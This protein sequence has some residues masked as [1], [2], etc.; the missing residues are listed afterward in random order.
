METKL[1]TLLISALGV[2]DNFVHFGSEHRDYVTYTLT[3][4]FKD[5]LCIVRLK[6]FC[7]YVMAWIGSVTEE[8]PCGLNDISGIAIFILT[9]CSK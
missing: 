7:G 8:N 1:H 5:I 6:H 4:T 9:V 2:S 3:Y